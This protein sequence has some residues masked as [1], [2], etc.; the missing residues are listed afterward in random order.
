[1][2]YIG[3][4]GSEEQL[5]PLTVQAQVQDNI[6]CIYTQTSTRSKTRFSGKK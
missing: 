4:N 1:M 6:Y 5:C 2:K 3:K